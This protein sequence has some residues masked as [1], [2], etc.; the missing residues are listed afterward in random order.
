MKY[1]PINSVFIDDENFKPAKRLKCV[2][3]DHCNQCGY[4]P[5]SPC[6]HGIACTPTSR[7]DGKDVYF[8]E[9]DEP[10]TTEP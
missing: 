3:G 7:E 6:D 5:I 2:E 9:T 8:I 4:D 1:H 10:L